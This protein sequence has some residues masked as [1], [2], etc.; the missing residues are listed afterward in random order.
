[1]AVDPLEPDRPVADRG[2]ELGGGREAAEVPAL[3]V[4]AAADDPARRRVGGG[5]GGDPLLRLGER[6]GVGKVE[7]AAPP[8]RGP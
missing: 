4:P 5:I 6:V 8:C 1:M 3:L 2:V 7:L